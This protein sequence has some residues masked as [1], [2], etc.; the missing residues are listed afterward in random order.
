LSGALPSVL[1]NVLPHEILQPFGLTGSDR[2]NHQVVLPARL[3]D[4]G[5]CAPLGDRRGRGS[6]ADLGDEIDEFEIA[7]EHQQLAVKGKI[8][9]IELQH[10][11]VQRHL[12]EVLGKLP[13]SADILCRAVLDDCSSHG[14]FENDAN[15]AD[16]PRPAAVRLIDVIAAVLHVL[17]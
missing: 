9:L 10:R 8:C 12:I 2:I 15:F 6:L 5:T 17:D 16:L 13:E 4:A 3:F 7:A 11:A 1:T 14:R